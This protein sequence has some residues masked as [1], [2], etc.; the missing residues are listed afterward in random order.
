[1]NCPICQTD[2]P[3]NARF[4]FNCGSVLALECAHCGTSL[5]A[6]AK[7]CFN[8]GQPTASGQAARV[9]QQ[10]P[11]VI[12][13]D[14]G[15]VP[16]EHGL[17][18]ESIDANWLNR[19]IPQNL[20]NK[21]EAARRSGLAEGE[22]RIVTILFCDVKGSTAAAADLDPEEW[23]EIM[24]GAFEPMIAPI[25]RYE[26]TVAHLTG[27]GL[28]AFF[29]APIAH[30]DD[31]QRAV[32][33]GL[34]I[35]E[36][37]DEYGR[38]VQ[39][40]WGMEF[41][42]RVGINTGLVV[43]GA[44]GSDL[45]MEYTALGN[46]INLAA[47]MEQTAELGSVQIAEATHKLVAPLFEFEDLGGIQVKGLSEPVHAYRVL[48]AKH[49][50]G[51]V[52]GL[53]GLYAPLIGRAE[54]TAALRSAVAELQE[55]HGRIISIMGE[56]GL[57]KSRLA[58][59]LKR[60]LSADPLAGVAWLE[61]RSQS[62]DRATP[63][64]P[65]IEILRDYFQLDGSM[66]GAQQ[67]ARVKER[68]DELF[69]SQ[70]EAAAPFFASVLALPLDAEDAE[71]IKYLQPPEL[72][73][74]IFSQI[75]ELLRKHLS[76]QSLVLYLDDLHW[77]DPTSL[78]L[79][80]SLLPLVRSY[81]LLIITAFRPRKQEP[82]WV[83]H[84]SAE[85]DYYGI[86]Q[87]LSLS[88]L[89]QAQSRELLANLLAI[90]GLP[91]EVR[92][93]ILVKSEGNPFFVEETIRTLLDND[94]IARINGRWQAKTE[95]KDIAFPD[96]LV[97]VITARLD[98]LSE[99]TRRIAQAAAV[100]GHEFD[101]PVLS[102]IVETPGLMDEAIRELQRRE[103]IVLNQQ[104]PAQSF[105]FKHILT[106]EAAYNSLLLS[107]RRELHRRAAESLQD[108]HGDQAA[109]IARH[110]LEARSPA[111]ALPFLV[112]AGDRSA[113]AYATTEAIE[114]YQR[115]IDLREEAANFDVIRRAYEG[116]GNA[117]AFANRGPE[118]IE[119][120]QK[121]LAFGLAHN[122]T[123][124]Q[125]SALNKMAAT[126]GLRMGQFPMAN[127]YLTR[128][129]KLLEETSEPGGAA[130][131][132]LIRCQ[133]CTAQAD[134][135]SVLLHMGKLA[136]LGEQVGSKEYSAMGLEHVASSLM[137]LT[138]FDEAQETA[139][140]ALAAAREVGD[141][142]HEAMNLALTLPMCAIRN[143]HFEEAKA[144][145]REGVEI[146][147]RINALV[148]DVVGKWLLAEIARWQ[149]EYEN[150]LAYNNEALT[151]ALPY[152][153][154]LPWLVVLVLGSHGTT[155]LQISGHFKE[156]IIKFH[157]HALK[158]LESPGGSMTAGSTW[159][160]L[161]FCAMT[162]GDYELAGEVFDKGLHYPTMFMHIE[163][164][165]LL[166]G[167]ALL[168]LSRGDIDQALM[169]AEDALSYARKRKMLHM[170]PIVNLALGKA[171]A[172]LERY[173]EALTAFEESEKSASSLAMRPDVWKAQL[174]AATVLEQTGQV[175]E[176]RVKRNSAKTVVEE[177]AGVFADETLKSAY[178]EA[179]LK[180]C[181]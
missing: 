113:S 18:H 145:L 152:E 122:D 27:D 46:A 151:R 107:N 90:D 58:A 29:G 71:R 86:Y 131:A 45:R 135:E 99:S 158:L 108:R 74:T 119:V 57:G 127:E 68:L 147:T 34:A 177:I 80:Y 69:P 171:L 66:S 56:A 96:T 6:G 139:L 143:G 130:E 25:Y 167:S 112:Q 47:R 59:E 89:D 178:L 172:A 78:E 16:A 41:E 149:G 75:Y 117:L 109:D 121:L 141:R 98:A 100:I 13:Q 84:E 76:K 32:L 140:A 19:Y 88:S 77:V 52:R 155:Y 146:S 48:G 10:A 61:G 72:R 106:Q 162:L 133:M 181:P 103:L 2:N 132:A 111:R 175:S 7:F 21:L 87:P 126:S 138:R 94:L 153:T 156:Q 36:A 65:F 93:T 53:A 11:A 150:A 144:Y 97:G 92:Q 67:I 62:F 142:E 163:R 24:N 104:L 64:A 148:P 165:R 17:T 20:I 85:R 63:F 4:C 116:L 40:K 164:P 95:I 23:T 22:R 35:I 176:A 14:E 168:A 166:A 115:A 26:G 8:C 54:Q 15:I 118:A 123:A 173:D 3:E 44:M 134:F 70:G 170:M 60:E 129:E 30:E 110:W 28:M 49:A 55:G 31:P 154:M 136:A 101:Y 83:F 42:I 79:L 51:S 1:V 37:I 159:V 105:M 82:S 39:N 81:P 128:S 9:E 161:G 124:A 137:W 174:A 114:L 157:H 160:E 125:I 12:K 38:F 102:E 73:G 50:P 179:A 169:Q 33:A 180:E 5:P 120:F 43:V 91:E